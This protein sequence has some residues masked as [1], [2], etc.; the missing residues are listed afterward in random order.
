MIQ[1]NR[2]IT[3]QDLI[4]QYVGFSIWSL[5]TP[6]L[7]ISQAALERNVEAVKANLA[8]ADLSSLTNNQQITPLLRVHI[9]TLKALE[10]TRLASAPSLS[11][12][13]G[14]I[15]CSTLEEI[16][17]TLPLVESGEITDI[18]YGV[19]PAKSYLPQLA[20]FRHHMR[21]LL[22]KN[23]ELRLVIDHPD[24]L[25]M[26]LDETNGGAP[27]WTFF[28]KIN[29]GDN[30]AGTTVTAPEFSAILN[31]VNSSDLG[32]YGIYCHAGGSYS[33]NDLA[34]AQGHL[35]RELA[36]AIQAVEAIRSHNSTAEGEIVEI[37][38]LVMSIG[39]TPTAS[40]YSGA[41]IEEFQSHWPVKTRLEIHAGNFV[42]LDLQQ[43]ATG[44]NKAQSDITT[45][46]LAEITSYYPERSEYMV[47]AGVLALAREP[48]RIKGVAV[49]EN[50]DGWVVDRVS[51][52]HGILKQLVSTKDTESATQPWKLGDKVLLLPQH[53]CITSSCHDWYFVEKDH[54]VI[55]VWRP[56]RH[57]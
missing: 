31:R 22:N 21:T 47:N 56:C 35:K 9:K 42:S 15:I 16:R 53:A 37:E 52:E 46:V 5:P 45:H 43:V 4:D 20:E 18:L 40:V 51:Q 30:R 1:S 48:G 14:R 3:K 12:T 57:W 28:L 44:L 19:P 27:D 10:V 39:A 34:A 50:H 32:L 24:Q 49:V 33:G 11:G 29:C 25:D 36:A 17:Q 41:I 8:V 54:I 7:I 13:N 26:A 23:S 38:D 55:D 2:E 6:S